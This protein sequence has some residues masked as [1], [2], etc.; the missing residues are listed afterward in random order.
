MTPTPTGGSRVGVGSM[1]T[2]SG[3]YEGVG[4]ANG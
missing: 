3:P 4:G 2:E 1:V